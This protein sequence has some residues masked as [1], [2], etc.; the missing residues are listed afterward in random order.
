MST[1]VV[2]DD[3]ELVPE[4][5]ELLNV[6]DDGSYREAIRDAVRWVEIYVDPQTAEAHGGRKA[7]KDFLVQELSTAAE[8]AGTLQ[9]N[10]P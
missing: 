1:L 2:R 7:V 3:A 6:F 10:P 9:G 5:Y 8:L 4:V